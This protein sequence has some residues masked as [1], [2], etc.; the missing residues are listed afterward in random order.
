MLPCLFTISYRF[1]GTGP[2]RA[3]TG[4][5][6]Q[7]LWEDPCV[8]Q[9]CSTAGRLHLGRVLGPP[10]APAAAES[11]CR[12]KLLWEHFSLP[13]ACVAGFCFK[14]ALQQ[15]AW[16]RVEV[17]ASIWHRF[18]LDF[19]R[20]AMV[21]SWLCYRLCVTPGLVAALSFPA[22]GTGGCRVLAP[23][24]GRKCS[25]ATLHFR[26]SFKLW[27]YARGHGRWLGPT[28]MRVILDCFKNQVV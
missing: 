28:C 12:D 10:R 8:Q 26:S 3:A 27:R 7:P 2:S 1:Q 5:F 4:A 21:R 15:I 6:P 22:A 24:G 20:L 11:S 16:A 23:N 14:C 9:C 19:Q 13:P 17:S 18:P 25:E